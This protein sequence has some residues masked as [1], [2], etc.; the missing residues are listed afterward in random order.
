[1][2]PISTSRSAFAVVLLSLLLLA[3]AAGETVARGACRVEEGRNTCDA[4]VASGK[5]PNLAMLQ[6]L[7]LQGTATLPERDLMSTDE[8]VNDDEPVEDVGEPAK[9]QSTGKARSADIGRL[10]VDDDGAASSLNEDTIE[11]ETLNGVEDDTSSDAGE[12]IEEQIIG[13][14]AS[15]NTGSIANEADNLEDVGETED[16]AGKNVLGDAEAGKD[17]AFNK[18]KSSNEH[19]EPAVVGGEAHDDETDKDTHQIE[20][21]GQDLPGNKDRSSDED[22]NFA[23]FGAEA[24]EEQVDKDNA[25]HKD[26]NPIEHEAL[27]SPGEEHQKHEVGSDMSDASAKKEKSVLAD[28]TWKEVSTPSDD[29]NADYS[30]DDDGASDEIDDFDD[31]G[32]NKVADNDTSAEDADTILESEQVSEEPAT[33]NGDGSPKKSDANGDKKAKT[34]A[35][36]DTHFISEEKSRATHAS[37]KR[38]SASNEDETNGF[39]MD[40][41]AV[42]EESVEEDAESMASAEDVE[43]AA[44]AADVEE[45]AATAVAS[46]SHHKVDNSKNSDNSDKSSHTPRERDDKEGDRKAAGKAPKEQS[47]ASRRSQALLLEARNDIID[48][49]GKRAPPV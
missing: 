12:A 26:N 43:E 37:E 44:S 3:V 39:V 45:A 1:M 9:K 42:E 18:G 32:Q 6:T 36:P 47:H 17:V 33:T 41:A 11:E 20:V 19:A 46:S 31:A 25:G 10:T 29:D 22:A 48:E 24:Q 27:A 14:D 28:A 4:A 40:D 49:S 8:S 38:A 15:V 5:L 2:L 35:S 7:A 30:N 21:A 34:V 16:A 13:K 23:D